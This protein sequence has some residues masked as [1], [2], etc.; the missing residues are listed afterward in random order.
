MDKNGKEITKNITY[1]LKFIYSVKFIS[2]SLSNLVEN[3]SE[4]IDKIKR[5]Y[6]HNNEKCEIQ[7]KDCECNLEYTNVKDELLIYKC[8]SCKGNYK[9]FDEDLQKEFANLLKFCSLGIHKFIL[10]LWKVVY[11]F[12]YIDDWGKFIE[13]SLHEKEEIYIKL[14][15]EDILIQIPNTQKCVGNNLK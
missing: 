2:C 8:L 6:R 1:K 7:Y 11:P 15:M 9:K 4:G 12:E 13:R 10:M 14:N 3:L 5:K